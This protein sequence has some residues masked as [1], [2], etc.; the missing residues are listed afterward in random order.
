M[1]YKIF[2]FPLDNP[3]ISPI[4]FE[5]PDGWEPMSV[6]L[7]EGYKSLFRL[8]ILARRVSE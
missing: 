2:N 5:L 3:H 4:P 7:C 1:E 6:S 8:V